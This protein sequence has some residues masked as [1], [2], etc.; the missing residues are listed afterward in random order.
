MERPDG[1]VCV[2]PGGQRSAPAPPHPR[3]PASPGEELLYAWWPTSGAASTQ[4]APLTPG[5]VGQGV[6]SLWAHETATAGRAVLGRHCPQGTIKT[7]GWNTPQSFWEGSLIQLEGWALACNIQD[8][9]RCSQGMETGGYSLRTL[10]CPRSQHLTERSLHP[11]SG[12]LVFV[13]TARS[14]LCFSWPYCPAGLLLPGA[15]GL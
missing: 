2:W 15:T 10:P 9:H 11:F 6:S 1:S 13:A 4:K 14:H 5:S 3:T 8:L 12:T 7:L